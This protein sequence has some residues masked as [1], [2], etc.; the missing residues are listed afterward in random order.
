MTS[1]SFHFQAPLSKILVAPLPECLNWLLELAQP[2]SFRLGDIDFFFLNWSAS[3]LRV[4]CVFLDNNKMLDLRQIFFSI[5]RK[6]LFI[7]GFKGKHLYRWLLD[8]KT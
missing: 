1:Q 8:A 3:E 4:F 5:K 7:T 6:L 2:S